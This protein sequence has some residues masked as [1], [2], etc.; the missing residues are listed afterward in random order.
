MKKTL[1]AIAG[2]NVIYDDSLPTVSWTAGM[3]IDAD[4]ANGQHGLRAAYMQGN[5]G[6]E[7]L[8]NAGYPRYPSSYRD[9]LVCDKDGNPIVKHNG[10]IVSR[11]TYKFPR[12]R[13]DDPDA[14][15][16]ANF[17]PYIVVPPQ[18]RKNVPGIVIGC[19]GQIYW[20]GKMIN[21]VVADVGP[22]TK[23]G[24]ASMEAARRLGIDSNPRTGGRTIPDVRYTIWPGVQAE[25]DG[26]KYSLQQ[27]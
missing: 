18:I 26:V 6:L 10:V 8:K 11:T 5:T 22:S 4:G 16:D 19:L 23:I 20:N 12:K 21:A 24:E 27:A 2:I 14:W 1:C 7:N 13:D 25:I 15:V 9:I 17:V 3:R